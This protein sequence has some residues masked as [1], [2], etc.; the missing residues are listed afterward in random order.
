MWKVNG[1]GV[2]GHLNVASLNKQT[3]IGK[4]ISGVGACQCFSPFYPLPF[5]TFLLPC[6]CSHPSTL[7]I[8]NLTNS[9]VG[10]PASQ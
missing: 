6:Y 3:K 10:E 1:V 2:L 9:R 5:P 7:R 4:I 8:T